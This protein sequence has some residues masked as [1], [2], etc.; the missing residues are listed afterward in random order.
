[1]TC[2]ALSLAI[3]RAC[4]RLGLNHT[5]QCVM[6]NDTIVLSVTLPQAPASGPT[7][8]YGRDDLGR[9]L[10]DILLVGIGDGLD[11]YAWHDVATALLGAEWHPEGDRGFVAFP[12]VPWNAQLEQ[13][14]DASL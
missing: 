11:G 3:A 13:Q 5:R 9:L 4:A 8:G 10:L 7:R 2:S 14:F 12:G 1:M 6:A